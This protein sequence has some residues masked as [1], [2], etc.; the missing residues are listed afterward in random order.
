M[1]QKTLNFAQSSAKEKDEINA[2]SS[3][4]ANLILSNNKHKAF[5]ER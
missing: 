3:K 4:N 5:A 1:I 2:G